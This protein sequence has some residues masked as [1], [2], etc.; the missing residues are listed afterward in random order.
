MIMIW[1]GSAG[2]EMRCLHFFTSRPHGRN[3]SFN[4]QGYVNLLHNAP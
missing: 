2:T 4:T 1:D 3:I